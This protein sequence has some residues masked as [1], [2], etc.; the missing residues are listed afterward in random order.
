M[1]MVYKWDEYINCEVSRWQRDECQSTMQNVF[2][3]G[4]GSRQVGDMLEE[5]ANRL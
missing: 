5:P 4:K 1:L 2:P 3:E